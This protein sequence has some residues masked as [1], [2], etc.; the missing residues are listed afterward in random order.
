MSIRDLS[1][2][3]A[4]PLTLGLF[5]I[6]AVSGA[7]LFVHVGDGLFHS[8]HE[9]LSMVLLVPFVL[10]VWRNWRAFLGYFKRSALWISV[11]VCA[12]AA[13]GFAVASGTSSGGNPLFQFADRME[14]APISALAPALG[15]DETRLLDALTAAGLTPLSPADSIKAIAARTGRDA[16]EVLAIVNGAVPAAPATP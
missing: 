15:T 8:M 7:A 16:F 12:V 9:I 11:A 5:T 10:H 4:T 6:S 3:Y 13:G 2:R 1:F 14:S